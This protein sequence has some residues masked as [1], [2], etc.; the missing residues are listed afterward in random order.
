MIGAIKLK[1]TMYLPPPAT[2]MIEGFDIQ[3]CQCYFN[4]SD[5][6]VTQPRYTLNR[7][8]HLTATLNNRIIIKYIQYINKQCNRSFTHRRLLKL[9][10]RLRPLL[11]TMQWSTQDVNCPGRGVLIF[12]EELDHHKN[13]DVCTIV[14]RIRRRLIKTALSHMRGRGFF[15][16]FGETSLDKHNWLIRILFYRIRKYLDRGIEI[17]NLPPFY[18]S[19]M[20]QLP[21]SSEDT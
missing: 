11:P 9:W 12:S 8:T 6:I 15:V 18:A 5:I 2:S 3:G 20:R 13:R 21:T 7:Q 1:Q 4:G 14:R 19:V 10:S 17:L 16:G